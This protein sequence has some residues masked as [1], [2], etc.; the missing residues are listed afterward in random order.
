MPAG[1]DLRPA[2]RLRFGRSSELV[3]EP[4]CDGGMKFDGLHGLLTALARPTLILTQ[5]AKKTEQK[6]SRVATFR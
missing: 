5:Q 4:P 6:N 1:L 2:S 3:F